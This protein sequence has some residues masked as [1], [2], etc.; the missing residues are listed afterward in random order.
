M[1]ETLDQLCK[2]CQTTADLLK[3]HARLLAGW[4]KKSGYRA[5]CPITTVLLEL[6]P[7]ERLVAQAGR[8]AYGARISALRGKLEA[9]GFTPTR[10]KRLAQ[11][12][13]SSL[14]GA[15][16]QARVERSRVPIITTADE[17]AVM[18]ELMLSMEVGV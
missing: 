6:A 17:L 7:Q 11:L 15:L 16:I 5:G 8:A 13:T 14:Q 1:V 9:D 2:E 18:Q 3:A 10:A 4:M 12:R